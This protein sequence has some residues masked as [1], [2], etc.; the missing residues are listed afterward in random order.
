[1]AARVRLTWDPSPAPELV[2]G[3]NVYE[4]GV[5][6]G[7]VVVPAFEKDIVP[8]IYAYTVAP[9]NVWGEGPLSDPVSTPPLCTKLGNISISISV[10]VNA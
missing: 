2:T 9:V 6:A 4:D 8:G 10:T 5:L 1:M 7:N 3:Y